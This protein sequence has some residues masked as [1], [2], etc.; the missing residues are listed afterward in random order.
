MPNG[1]KLTIETAAADVHEAYGASDQSVTL[2]QYVVIV[3]SDTGYGMSDTI[4]KHAFEPFFT[5][6]ATGQGTGLGLSQVYGFMKQSG[7]HVKLYSELGQGTTVKLY[8][9]RTAGKHEAAD[10]RPPTVIPGHRKETVLVVEDNPHVREHTCELLRELGYQVIEAEDGASALRLIERTE[11]ISLLFT[12]VGL[13]GMNGREL[14]ELARRRRPDIRIL[15]TTG[16]ARDLASQKARAG[17]SAQVVTKP[18]TYADLAAKVREALDGP[19][20]SP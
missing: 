19:P 4:L 8:L 14:A 16:Y 2:G 3:V 11:T 6:K 9:P 5:T 13:P 12:D 1:G 10:P 15:Y 7:G 20:R 18:Y 17:H